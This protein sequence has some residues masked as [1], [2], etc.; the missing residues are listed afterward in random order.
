MIKYVYMSGLL[1]VACLAATS[2]PAWAANAALTP[3]AVPYYSPEEDPSGPYTVGKVIDGI[4]GAGIRNMG[5][6][7]DD[8]PLSADP[9]E[10]E[11]PIT[12]HLVFDLG[13]NYDVY[14][15]TIWSRGDTAIDNSYLPDGIDFFY[16]LDNNSANVQGAID[17]IEGDANI[18]L[19]WNGNLQNL[20]QGE[21]Q[22]ISFSAPINTR[23]VGM[24]VNSSHGFD[25]FQIGEQAFLVPEE[26]LPPV[27]EKMFITPVTVA[28]HS[29]T[30]PFPYNVEKIIDGTYGPSTFRNMASFTDDTDPLSDPIT[31]HFVLDLGESKSW[32]GIRF[33]SRGDSPESLFP[34]DVD[35][36]YYADDDWSN[37]SL[38]DDIEGDADIISI[39]SGTLQDL[40]SGA[41]ELIAFGASVNKRYVGVRVN[42]SYG[43]DSFQLGEVEL[44]NTALLLPGDA[45]IDGKVDSVD[46]G[47]LAENWLGAQKAWKQGDFN[48]DGRVDDID[49]TMLASNWLKTSSSSA[50]VPEPGCASLLMGLAVAVFALRRRG[51][52]VG[53]TSRP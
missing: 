15:S 36:F 38:A 39:W 25:T 33:W 53:I 17:D 21:P 31:G 8:T 43:W 45:N 13:K 30:E 1:L 26:Q 3:V 42:S 10:W 7:N 2:S 16:F 41:D 49:A 9:Y 24:R 12:G 28:N 19:L 50:A 35:V 27:G 40:A 20:G 6:F 46:A 37:N 14:G 5:V 4:H 23:Y 52:R 11:A 22:T 18:A 34:K 51:G 32:G 29:G 47:I 44:V 48:G